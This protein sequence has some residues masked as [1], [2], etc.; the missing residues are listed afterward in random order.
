MKVVIIEDEVASQEYLRNILLNHF[1]QLKV[2]ALVDNVPDAVSVLN[3][4]Q[5]DIVFLDVEIK[6][7]TGFDVLVQLPKRSFEVVFT[8]AFNTFA[9]EAFRFHAIDYLLKPLNTAEVIEATE[10]CMQRVKNGHDNTILNKLLE[11]LNQ[12]VVQKT[13]LG[14][15]TLEGIEFIEVPDIVYGE[16]KGNYTEL[17]MKNGVKITTSKKLK[18]IE[19]SLPRQ[20]FFRIHHSYIVNL[21]YVKKYHKGRGGYL[22]LHDG[23]SL[24]VSSAKKDDFMNWLG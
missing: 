24:P 7:G 8:T 9:L 5:P 21:Q 13:K 3:A 19:E 4:H 15:H 6:L 22:V 1:P 17:W 16:A 2:V 14:I 10:R 20:M 18:D 12:P 11:Q 23:Q